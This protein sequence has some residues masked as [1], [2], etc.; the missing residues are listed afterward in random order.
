MK[1]IFTKQPKVLNI[2][3]SEYSRVLNMPLV[4]KT[5]GFRI[6]QDSKYTKALNIFVFWRYSRFKKPT[7]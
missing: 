5:P 3:G 7:V 4:L 1:T 6:C 2:E